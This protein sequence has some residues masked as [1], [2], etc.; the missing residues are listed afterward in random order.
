MSKHYLQPPRRFPHPP[1]WIAV[2]LFAA[3]W[4]ALVEQS[5]WGALFCL[6]LALIPMS[7]ILGA[8]D[9]RIFPR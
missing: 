8:I 1:S 9:R 7:K 2:F 3:A 5:W 6:A 4:N